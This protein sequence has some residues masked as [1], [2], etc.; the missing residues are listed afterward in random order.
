MF[1]LALP[2]AAIVLL[3][4]QLSKWWILT[5][6]MDP[7][8]DIAVTSFFVVVLAL[9]KGISF[10]Q[11]GFVSPWILS[12]VALAIVGGLVAWLH[13]MRRPWPAIAI[14]CVIGGALGNVIDRVRFG[15]VVDFLYFHW[16]EWGWPAFNLADSAITVGVAMLLIDGLF[17]KAEKASNAPIQGG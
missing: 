9:N 15:A 16:R 10:S 7:P 1:R 14:A 6:V 8:R 5:Q 2:I 3:A 12:V 17:H 11:L 4:D 13:R